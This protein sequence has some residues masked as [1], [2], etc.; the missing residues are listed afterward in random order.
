M[1]KYTIVQKDGFNFFELTDGHKEFLKKVPAERHFM[2]AKT[3][4]SIVDNLRD[5]NGSRILSNL[6]EEKSTLQALRNAVVMFY[7]EQFEA[8]EN[9]DSDEAYD[10][11]TKQSMVVHVIDMAMYDRENLM[12]ICRKVSNQLR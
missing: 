1:S 2:T 8:C 6:F 3:A 11:F 5:N 7:E 9:K 4:Y 10:Q 12:D